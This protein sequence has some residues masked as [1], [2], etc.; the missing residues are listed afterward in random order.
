[1]RGTVPIERHSVGPVSTRLWSSGSGAPVVYLHG[2]EHH[3]GDA[4]FL[5]RLAEQH[6]VFAPEHP[7]Y[8]TSEGFGL[9]EDVLDVVLHYRQ[10]IESLDVDRVHVIGHCF[11]GMIA[12]EL[13]AICPQVVDRLV[14]VDALGLWLEDAQPVDLFS[15]TDPQMKQ[16]K[17]H[18]P[19]S[20]PKPEPSIFEA[21][22][23]DPF[24]GVICRNQNLAV[25]SKFLWPI[26]DR[27]LRKR[28]PLVQAETL[29][30]HGESDGLLPVAHGEEF[31]AA[32]PGARL[33]TVPRA[34]HLPMFEREQ[35]FCDLVL[36]FLAEG[37]SDARS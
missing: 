7:G 5:H 14:L 36:S 20:A 27:G 15:L 16:A 8:G 25:A 35:E 19:E 33:V 18:D 32:I 10:F 26:P 9:L 3:P 13:A 37:R 11:G 1:M 17:W 21:D 34:G 23:E 30:V 31:A 12:A 28:L 4:S 6:R 24:A 22:P 2:F 29:V